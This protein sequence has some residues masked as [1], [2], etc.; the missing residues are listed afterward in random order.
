MNFKEIATAVVI[1]AILSG[2]GFYLT[3]S[4]KMARLDTEIEHLKS[5]TRSVPTPVTTSEDGP[6][7]TQPSV[8]ENPLTL[9]NMNRAIELSN[10]EL[11]PTFY[12]EWDKGPTSKKFQVIKDGEMVKETRVR[13]G[14]NISLGDSIRGQ[15][16]FKTWWDNGTRTREEVWVYV[17]DI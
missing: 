12:I 6:T 7:P 10:I 1:G 3:L 13:N 8:V 5:D 4:N 14:E 11:T 9:L 17:V 16:E 2:A 15:C